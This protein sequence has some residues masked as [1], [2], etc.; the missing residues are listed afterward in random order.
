M[1]RGRRAKGAQFLEAN[2]LMGQ[3]QDVERQLLEEQI[4]LAREQAANIAKTADEL[5]KSNMFLGEISSNTAKSSD[6]K[7]S[8]SGAGS[9]SPEGTINSFMNRVNQVVWSPA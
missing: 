8:G 3:L 2:E 7:G 6:G 5:V 9:P 4:K 1:A